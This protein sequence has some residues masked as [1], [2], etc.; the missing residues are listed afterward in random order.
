MSLS[1]VSEPTTPRI[2]DCVLTKPLF[3]HHQQ[4]RFAIMSIRNANA[5]PYKLEIVAVVIHTAH[6]SHSAHSTHASHASHASHS[7]HATAH[8]CRHAR[9]RSRLL[10]LL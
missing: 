5:T 2:D 10:R 4:H 1:E 6:T 9:R 3:C 8:T 7:A